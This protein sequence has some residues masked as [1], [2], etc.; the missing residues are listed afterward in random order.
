M[1][2]RCLYSSIGLLLALVLV[3]GICVVPAPASARELGETVK[4]QGQVVDAEGRPVS[5]VQVVLEGTRAY[6]SVTRMRKKERGE[7]RVSTTTNER[8]EFTLQWTWDRFFNKLRL[9][10]GV[11]VHTTDGDDFHVL[12]EL[13]VTRRFEGTGPVAATLRVSDTSYLESFRRFMSTL[14]SD[15]EHR[16]YR[17]LGAPDEVKVTELSDRTE[18]AWWYFALGKVYRFR[19]GRLHGSESFDPVERF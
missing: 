11:P 12:E 5:D 4:V 8:G 10:A 1:I 9:R 6:F 13:D 18:T 3:L 16:V 17:Q 7:R 19:D 14:D 15:D 2:A